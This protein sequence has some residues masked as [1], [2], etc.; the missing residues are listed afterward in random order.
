MK[1]QIKFATFLFIFTQIFLLQSIFA[2][3]T[4]NTTEQSALAQ[5]VENSFVATTGDAI[6]QFVKADFSQRRGMLNQWPASIEEL[7]QLVSY[8]DQNELYS[9]GSG[10][11]Y[12]LKNDENLLSY[13]KLEKIETWPSDL[14]QVTL[15]NTL[16]KALSFGQAKLKLESEEAS[17]R[18]DAID[19]LENNL[20]EIDSNM[21]KG[22]YLKENNN[23]VKARLEQLMARLDYNSPDVLDKIR[24]VEILKQSNRPDV[25]AMI[26]QELSQPN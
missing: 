20:T 19:I 12:I 5:D 16:R 21:V 3:N 17:Q 14:S 9:D 4:L 10:Q 2:Q 1:I 24:A 23:K 11:T 13:P 6:Q 26:E 25:L 7:D 22:L 18:L 8:I 15:V